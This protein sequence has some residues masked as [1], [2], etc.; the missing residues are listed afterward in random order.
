M[1]EW[2]QN[3]LLN[4]LV[5]KKTNKWKKSHSLIHTDDKKESLQTRMDAHQ[6]FKNNFHVITW[7]FLIYVIL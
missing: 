4:T 6:W 2:I 1:N 5:L 3:I 7:E